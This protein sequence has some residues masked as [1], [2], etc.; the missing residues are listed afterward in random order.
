MR[1]VA[2]L[3]ILTRQIKKMLGAE[4]H[5]L[6]TSLDVVDKA[7]PLYPFLAKSVATYNYSLSN[8]QIG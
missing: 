5:A 1:A 6:S 8:A 4:L 3:E 7:Y 2:R